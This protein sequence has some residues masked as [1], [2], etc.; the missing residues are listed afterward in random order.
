M[1][2]VSGT[3]KLEQVGTRSFRLIE[4]VVYDD[5]A[6]D[7]GAAGA[8]FR[9]PTGMETDLASVPYVLWSILSPFGKQTRPAIVHDYQCVAIPDELKTL[10]QRSP[11]RRLY[12]ESA[13]A[14]FHAAL[15]LE[16]VPR[17]RA[18]MMWTG[19]TIGRYWVNGAPWQRWALAAELVAG[20]VAIVWGALHLTI[21]QGW[22]A[23]LAP[24]AVAVAAWGR[25][26]VPIALAQYPGMLLVVMAITNWLIGV[27]EWIL[28]MIGGVEKSSQSPSQRAAKAPWTKVEGPTPLQVF[29]V[30]GTDRDVAAANV[31]PA[32]L[33]PFS[34][35][36]V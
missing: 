18:A 28:N 33:T 12:R 3:A 24:L 32:P 19:V 29:P 8:Q 4:D 31:P 34:P 13:D 1:P 11:A 6:D 27:V 17:F 36:P 26:R 16:G 9:A 30:K 7:A 10:P 14:R 20:Y 25:S 22:V 21:W 5:P 35:K 2:Y 15:K 23:L